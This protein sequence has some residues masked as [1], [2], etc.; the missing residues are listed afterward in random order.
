[1]EQRLLYITA[2][3]LVFSISVRSQ[4]STNSK[5]DTLFL[6]R[7]SVL[8]IGTEKYEIVR[9]T[10]F[11]VPYGTEYQLRIDRK[12]QTDTFF[13]SL[14]VRA[15]QHKWTERLHNIVVTAP[16]KKTISD[17]LQTSQSISP[18]VK[19]EGKVIRN[20]KIQRLTPFGPTI[21]DT[22]RIAR[23]ALEKAG[24]KIHLNTREKIISNYILFSEGDRIDPS[25][26]SDNERIIR[27]LS[28]IED[29]RIFIIDDPR[30]Q[31]SVDVLVLTK[32]AFS[33]GV[34][35]EVSDWDAGSVKIFENN[36]AGLGHELHASF[37][38]DG[39][40]DPWYGKEIFYIINNLGGTFI[41]SKVRYAQI[42]DKETFE[43]LFDRPFITPD[44]K[45]AGAIQ[46]EHTARNSNINYGDTLI[47]PTRI[48]YNLFDLWAGRSFSLTSSRTYSTERIN[49]V[50]A[51]R[52]Q[53]KYFYKRPDNVTDNTFYD[54]HNKTLWLS[55]FSI[56]SQKFFRSN[57]IYSFGRTE[58][59]PN[60]FLLNITFGPE[61]GEFNRRFYMGSGLA[62][63][64]L[65]GNLGYI[66]ANGE[67]GGFANSLKSPDQA[68]IHVKSNYFTNLFIINRFKIRQFVNFEYIKG[69]Q[70]FVDE[71]IDIE[72]DKGIRGYT[73]E[74][75]KGTKRATASCEIAVFSPYYFYGFRFVFFG[76]A[77]FGLISSSEPLLLSQLH[78][79]IGF[80]IR[81]KNE[82]LTIET[83][84]LR[85]GYYPSLPDETFPF[86]FDFSGEQKLNSK[87]FYVSK[88]D[89]IGF[90]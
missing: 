23:S 54:Y 47:V 10:V 6:S 72:N 90:E 58:D 4:D 34:G 69:V 87:D 88:P 49:F 60:G 8:I 36:L 77:D 80:G 3:L 43:I 26:L 73:N 40:K 21:F 82:R 9:D 12:T 85:L 50:I 24:N 63:G 56:T 42:F 37:H 13:D 31:D 35:G 14:E 39:S 79:G 20:I 5:S 66:Y 28:F 65:I 75:A 2:L 1:M 89:V 15:S 48:N 11:I 30:N 41:D 71:Y 22:T 18:F 52:V 83:I 33:I 74:L 61:F 53:S 45:Y 86:A 76:F 44:T 46:Y 70:R 62:W 68:V 55:S 64:G 27:H 17:T 32:D 7:G 51:T 29:A 57:L 84:Q 67:L 16:K 81:I 78:S 25:V 59:I 38:W 19:S